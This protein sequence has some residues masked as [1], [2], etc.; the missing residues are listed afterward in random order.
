MITEP[1]TGPRWFRPHPHALC[2]NDAEASPPPPLSR[3]ALPSAYPGDSDLDVE[4][5][6][7]SDT[8]RPAKRSRG[9]AVVLNSLAPELHSCQTTDRRPRSRRFRT[10]EYP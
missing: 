4:S 3:A 1:A 2:L 8:F 6:H 9:R 10:L 5:G 7:V